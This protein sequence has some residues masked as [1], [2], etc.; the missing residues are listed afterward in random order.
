MRHTSI[1][2][3]TENVLALSYNPLTLCKPRNSGEWSRIYDETKVKN[4]MFL[5]RTKH[6]IEYFY[7]SWFVEQVVSW[8]GCYLCC[9]AEG[10]KFIIR[11]RS[12]YCL[13]LS[14]SS[15]LTDFIETWLIRLYQL[16]VYFDADV[17]LGVA[18][19]LFRSVQLTLLWQLIE[20]LLAAWWLLKVRLATALQYVDGMAPA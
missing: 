1:L 3:Y 12:D 18:D 4:M 15:W 13:A 6:C 2:L 17:D 16:L 5:F 8:Y 19:S 20:G 14:V 7:Q 11:P 10:L 9:V